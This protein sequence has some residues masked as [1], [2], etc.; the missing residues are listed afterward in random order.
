MK[1]TIGKAVNVYN[2]LSGAKYSKLKTSERSAIIKARRPMK[3]IAVKFEDFRNDALKGLRPENFDKTVEVIRKFND[4]TED[5][6]KAALNDAEYLEALE[7]NAGFNKAV[8]DCVKDEAE[9]EIDLDITPI[10]KEALNKLLD[11]NTD[12]TFAIADL[13]EEV[14]CAKEE[15]ETET[16]D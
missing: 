15:T 12:W 1:T 7:E 5:E 16:E 9:K 10:T 6:R 8:E 11:S 4:M 14:L 3:E 2:L 13:L